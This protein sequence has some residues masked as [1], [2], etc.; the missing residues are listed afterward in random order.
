MRPVEGAIPGAGETNPHHLL[1]N[2]A[3]S[4]WKMLPHVFENFNLPENCWNRIY[5]AGNGVNRRYI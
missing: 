5:K 3:G 4:S 1:Q 2:Q